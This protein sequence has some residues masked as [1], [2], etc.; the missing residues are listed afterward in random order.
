MKRAVYVSEIKAIS[1]RY[2]AKGS[3]AKEI[4]PEASRRGHSELHPKAMVGVL[5][6]TANSVCSQSS[7]YIIRF[8]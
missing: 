4:F 5:I 7:D 6:L 1:K 2:F 8:S 3:L